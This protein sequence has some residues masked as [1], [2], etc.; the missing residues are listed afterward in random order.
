ME[1]EYSKKLLQ[2]LQEQERRNARVSLLAYAKA[3]MPGY[4][5][6]DHH[7]QI[8]HAL[9][10]VER[11]A[12]LR[13]IIVMP[14]RHGKS[15][16]ASRKFPAWYLARNPRHQMIAS[17]YAGELAV[18][19][20]RSVR[21]LMGSKD[22]QNVFKDSGLS[23]DSA[24]ANRW[25]TTE[26]GIYVA[27]GV[28][29][30]ITG[31]GAHILLIDDPIKDHEEAESEI[32]R[33]RLWNWYKSTAYTRLMPNGAIILIQTRWHED[34]L[35]GKLLAEQEK[36]EGDDWE[37]LHLKA[38]HEGRAL[39]PAWYALPALKKIEKV[40]GPREWQ[41]LY[42]GEPTPDEGV[43]FKRE[44][45]RYY[46]KLP[47]NM[48][49]YGASDYA[50]TE[51]DLDYTVHGVIGLDEN[52]DMYVVEIWRKQT[53]TD[54]WIEALFHLVQKWKPLVWGEEAGQIIKSVGPFILK[55]QIEDKIYF[56]REQFA[57]SVNK[58]IR[59]RSFEARMS[60][61]KVYFPR[62]EEW[63]ETLIS[64]LMKFPL[65]KNDD[66]V[67]VMSLFGRMISGMVGAKPPKEPR[68]E[69]DIND[70]M[71]KVTLSQ[72]F[73]HNEEIR[74]KERTENYVR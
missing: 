48:K 10:A 64:E 63:G 42:Q 47:E 33:K 71:T 1:R 27:A 51:D 26:G 34:D 28:G 45:V 56:H 55:R 22:H 62:N 61:G 13:Q 9:E 73:K 36:G 25:H 40:V 11:R 12:I 60:M 4:E 20:G 24:A 69:P 5:V 16:L 41:A 38:V 18:D 30:G 14:P 15:E 70:G 57:S 68:Q 65:G 7:Y 49:M 50:V 67:D 17:S 58:V 23:P 74:R 6:G 29:S 21:N 59:S 53:Q 39:W 3:V 46:D 37:V 43:N 66:Q 8:A 72:L 54:K 32:Y 2:A 35:V 52:D 19:F 44:W 31:K